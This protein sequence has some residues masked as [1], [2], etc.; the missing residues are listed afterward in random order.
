MTNKEKKEREKIYDE[1]IYPL[2]SQIIAICKANDMPMFCDIEYAEGDFS[3]TLIPASEKHFIY[4]CYHILRQCKEPGGVNIDKF[5][6]NA[7]G[8]FGAGSSV[9][10]NLMKNKTP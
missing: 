3:T 9:Y 10:L 7:E 5:L 4:E 2:M 6:I 8:K 1:Q